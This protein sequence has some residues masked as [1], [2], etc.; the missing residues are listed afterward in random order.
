MSLGLNES[1]MTAQAAEAAPG[2]DPG[3]NEGTR[4][5]NM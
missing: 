4:Q 1:R 2:G 5:E 3:E